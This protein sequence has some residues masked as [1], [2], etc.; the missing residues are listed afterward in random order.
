MGRI[1]LNI[2]LSLLTIK[3][4]IGAKMNQSQAKLSTRQGEVAD[5]DR[6]DFE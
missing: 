5:S 4:I 6:V 2:R 1:F 3:D